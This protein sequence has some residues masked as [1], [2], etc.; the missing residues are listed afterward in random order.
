MRVG[1]ISG[2]VFEFTGTRNGVSVPD[3]AVQGHLLRK[4][5]T[6]R[7]EVVL[8]TKV[9]KGVAVDDP[10]LENFAYI[11]GGDPSILGLDLLFVD[12]LGRDGATYDRAMVQIQQW[13]GPVVYHSYIAHPGWNPPF[14]Q[15]PDLLLSRKKWLILNRADDP[16]AAYAAMVGKKEQVPARY[17]SHGRI[18]FAQWEPFFM[19]EFPWRCAGE[20][21]PDGNRIYRQGY[22]GRLPR[23][24]RRRSRKVQLSMM[25]RGWSRVAYGPPAS[26]RWISEAT[27]CDDGGK[28]NNE[29][30]PHY[31]RSFDWIYQVAIDRFAGKGALGYRTHRLI[32]C[33]MAGVLQ[34]FDPMMGI[35]ELEPWEMDPISLAHLNRH[36][37]EWLQN[38]V[39]LQQELLLPR[40]NP[41][42]VMDNLET[43]LQ[44]AV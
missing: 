9:P 31:L 37:A 1:F 4:L 11:P 35:P 26:T 34:I 30:L 43:L 41:T 5:L 36:S 25:D 33:A 13:E 20:D 38:A 10:T 44:G 8:L 42:T 2:D 27:G 39:A 28:I 15:D 19:R 22:Y 23:T 16:R 29:D 24:E 21:K 14:T 6:W 17:V 18:R 3:Y 40:A 7:H 12:R 32:E